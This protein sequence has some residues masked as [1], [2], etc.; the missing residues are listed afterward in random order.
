MEM[1]MVAGL[2]AM[3]D[4]KNPLIATTYGVGEMLLH[5]A[6]RNV[7]HVLLGL[8][9]S[10]TNDCGIGLAHA[11]GFRF[12]DKTGIEVEPYPHNLEHL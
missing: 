4:N 7:K 6:D 1:V 11:L 12:L 9:G 8:G 2:P 3:G 10:A 5:A